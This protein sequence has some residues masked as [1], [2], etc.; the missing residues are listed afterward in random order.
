MIAVGLRLRD[1]GERLSW[2]EL[3]AF[4]NHLPPTGDSAV[5]RS[6]HPKSW[7]WTPELDFLASQLFALQIANWQ[8]AGGKGAKPQPVKRPKDPPKLDR[9][10]KSPDELEEKRKQM[11]DNRTRLL[12]KK[13]S[14]GD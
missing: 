6:E 4:I 12:R 11:Q 5:F 3:R 8:R 7:W 13:V 1:I 2:S 9:A 10:P 14:G